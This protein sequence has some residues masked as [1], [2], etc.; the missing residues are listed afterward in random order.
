MSKLLIAVRLL[1][2]DLLSQR[3]NRLIMFAIGFGAFFM[4]AG[5]G[6][7]SG[8][9]HQLLELM[10]DGYTGDVTIVADSVSLEPSPLPLQVGW[11]DLLLGKQETLDRLAKEAGV[12][13]VLGRL[14]VY[15]NIMGRDDSLNEYATIVGCD[16]RVERSILFGDC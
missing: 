2:K 7:N 3:K 8:M 12:K 10:R 1:L 5:G 6:Y 11:N 16:F 4:V 13:D 15:G 14:V 9:K